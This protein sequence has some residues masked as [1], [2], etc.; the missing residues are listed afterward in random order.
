MIKN[1][2]RLTSRVSL[3]RAGA[4]RIRRPELPLRTLG[5]SSIHLPITITPD[6]F[7]LSTLVIS[8]IAPRQRIVLF[9]LALAV[10]PPHRDLNHHLPLH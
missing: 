3:A 1:A 4:P 9:L 10:P 5:P 8:L 7:A 6:F 2:R